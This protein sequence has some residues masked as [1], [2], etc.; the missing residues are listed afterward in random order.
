MKKLEDMG[1]KWWCKDS[2]S[3]VANMYARVFDGDKAV[4]ALKTFATCFCIANTTFHMNGDTL[5]KWQV[6]VY[7]PTVYLGRL[8]CFRIGCT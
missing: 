2:C 1:L 5:K 6:W 4:E 8:L 3:W 7:L